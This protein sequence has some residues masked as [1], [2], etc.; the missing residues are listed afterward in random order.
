MWRYIDYIM[1]PNAIILVIITILKNTVIKSKNIFILNVQYLF[2]FI[3]H[4]IFNIIFLIL[5][6]FTKIDNFALFLEYNY[7]LN[8]LI[9]VICLTTFIDI[10]FYFVKIRKQ[11]INNKD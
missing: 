6:K 8:Y 4:L 11:K 10:I 5:N 7:L 2:V 9:Y 3:I 1:L